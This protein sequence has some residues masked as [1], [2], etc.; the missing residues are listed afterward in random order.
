MVACRGDLSLDIDCGQNCLRLRTQDTWVL[1]DIQLKSTFGHH[2]YCEIIDFG[3]FY[4]LR[5]GVIYINKETETTKWYKNKV[6]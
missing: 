4:I 1:L 6:L 2:Y 5:Y 3:R